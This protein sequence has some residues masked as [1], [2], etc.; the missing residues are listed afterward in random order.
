MGIQPLGTCSDRILKLL[1]FPSFCTSS[2]KI[3]FASLFYI[4]NNFVLFHACIYSPRAG[5]GGRQPFGTI[6]L[7]EEERSSLWSLVA[8]FKKC[9]CSLILCILFMIVYMYIASAGADNPFGPKFCCQQ[10]SL[11]TSTWFY[12]HLFMIIN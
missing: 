6:F 8:C 9:I 12:T 1:L 7:M 10:K 2:R 11:I 5:G 4:F 3:S